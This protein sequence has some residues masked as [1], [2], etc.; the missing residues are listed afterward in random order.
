M[1]QIIQDTFINKLEDRLK[2]TQSG[3]SEE[4]LQTNK[5]LLIPPCLKDLQENSEESSFETLKKVSN[6]F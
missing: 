1:I 4:K 5:A 3:K 6:F 2:T